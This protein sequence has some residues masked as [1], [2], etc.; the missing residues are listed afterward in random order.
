MDK[1]DFKQIGTVISATFSK[2]NFQVAPAKIAGSAGKVQKDTREYRLMLI[3]K[4][5]DTT[6]DLI[7]SFKTLLPSVIPGATN[8]TFNTISPNSSKFPSY[9]FIYQNYKFDVVISKGANKGE[10][11]ESQVVADLSRFFQLPSKRDPRYLQLIDSMNKSNAE[12]STRE[13][14]KVE[15]RKGSTKKE[16]VPIEQLGA[17]IGDIVLTD[18]SGS[19]WYISL[20]DVN[21]DTFSSYSGAASLFDRQGNL[22][23]NSE[24]ADFLRAFGVDLNLVQKGFDERNK[25]MI[26]RKN[27]PVVRSESSKIK[28]IFERA[29]GVNYF[30]VRRT[31]TGW[32][33]FWLDRNKLNSLAGNIRVTNIKYP[34]ITSKQL[35]IFCESETQKYL[36]EIRNSSGGEYPNDIKFKVRT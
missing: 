16:G 33:V 14:A 36:I 24:G 22:Q 13:I 11:F 18:T 2:Y 26:V 23:A 1:I 9:S 17:I 12:F 8:I 19:K 20:K 15:Q 10:N 3:N 31:A 32:K 4:Q 28:P 21:G 27:I 34:G 30:Y 35:S 5:R 29:W 6:K 7:A 25:V